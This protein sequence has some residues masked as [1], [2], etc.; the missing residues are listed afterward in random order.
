MT[1]DEALQDVQDAKA[2]GANA[3]ALNIGTATASWSTT[4]VSYLFDAANQV[5]DFKL[6][7]SFDMTGFSDPSQFLAYLASYVSNDAYYQYDGKPFVSTFS[8]SIL[9]SVLKISSADSCIG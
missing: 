3:F 5:G 4:S 9:Y 6:F 1:S 2:L 8:V 7:F